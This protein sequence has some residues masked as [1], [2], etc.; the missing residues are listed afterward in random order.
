M[1]A[2]KDAQ[3]RKRTAPTRGAS[4]AANVGH[5]GERSK[6][7]MCGASRL[8]RSTSLSTR[9]P[10]ITA[11]TAARRAKA[12]KRLP[13]LPG[14]MLNGCAAKCGSMDVSIMAI[15]AVSET[16]NQINASIGTLEKNSRR[17]PLG[18]SVKAAINNGE[19]LK[20]SCVLLSNL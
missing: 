8:W 20:S 2:R 18:C 19:R 4:C 13:I 1:A 6:P 15:G 5:G 11:T 16:V 7:K 10:V 9:A 12:A 14:D 17:L 3:M